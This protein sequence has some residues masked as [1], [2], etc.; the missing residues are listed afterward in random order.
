MIRRPP[1]STLFPY[2]TLFRSMLVARAVHAVS[3]ELQA[4]GVAEYR[5]GR[6]LP[7]EVDLDRR[8]GTDGALQPGMA[9]RAQRHGEAG[10]G[11]AGGEGGGHAGMGAAGGCAGL[12]EG[13]R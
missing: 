1:R 5:G 3:S 9:P 10:G 8:G 7:V 2:T 4:S 12:R 13:L 11:G 6:L